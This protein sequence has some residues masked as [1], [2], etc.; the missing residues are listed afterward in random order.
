MTTMQQVAL[1]ASVSPATVSKFLNTPHRVAPPTGKRI[2]EAIEELGYV[3]NDA[4][5][6][7]RAGSSTTIGLLAFDVGNPFFV[8]LARRM[9]GYAAGQ[10]LS[11][12]LANSD[13]SN[14][15]ERGYLELFEQQRV[16]GVLVSPVGDIEQ[17]LERLHRRDIPVVIV[18]KQVRPDL[19]ASVSIDDVEGGYMAAAHLISRGCQRLAFVG[20][21][22]GLRQADDRLAGAHRAAEAHQGVTIETI[23]VSDRSVDEGRSVGER[24]LLRP[25]AERPDGVFAMNDRL[26]F[27]LLQTLVVSGRV[28][29]PDEIAVIGYDDIEF[30]SAAVVPLSTIRQP[31]A[32][33]A[34][35]A[36]ELLSGAGGAHRQV[37]L[38]PQLV[39]RESTRQR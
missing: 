35:A 14:E 12:L 16:A 13:G 30:A 38:E 24:L 18:D 34:R 27:G 8:D 19:N 15:R 9:E 39:V 26:A 5:R 4:A 31:R 25:A 7:L 29:V 10:G 22:A 3:R 32:E 2:A 1:R 20:G 23:P 11:V 21:P 28:R 17:Q 6:Q 37:V 36:V 33:F